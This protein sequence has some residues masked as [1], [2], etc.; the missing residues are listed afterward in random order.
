[1]P[2]FPCPPRR[3][4]ALVFDDDAVLRA[5]IAVLAFYN[6]HWTAILNISPTQL[7]CV[8]SMP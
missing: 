3:A 4:G 5:G 2:G 6:L 8:V 7:G 1:M